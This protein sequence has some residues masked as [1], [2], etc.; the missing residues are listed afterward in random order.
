MV[1]SVS[2]R[3]T[4]MRLKLEFI[5]FAICFVYTL[6]DDYGSNVL[7]YSKASYSKE[8]P[9]RN[10]FVMFFAPWCGHCKRL[11]PTWDELGSKYNIA[12]SR[13]VTI[14]KVDCTV[15]TDLCSEEDVT[16]YPTIKYFP[17]GKESVR[18]KGSR[19]LDSL[20]NFLKQQTG[21][22]DEEVAPLG[23]PEDEDA[24]IVQT[25]SG[26]SPKELTE[27][28]FH[29]HI[30]KGLH[31][32]K[33]YAPWCGH[34]Q[35]LAPVWEQLAQSYGVDSSVQIGKID[36][37]SNRAI[38]TEFEIQ[39]YP[40][41]LWMQDGKVVE[42]YQ[43]PRN[44][45]DLKKYVDTMKAKSEQQTDTLQDMTVP[46][47][48]PAPVVILN[49]D[50]F[51]TTVE[52]GLT[53]VKFFAPWCGHCKR[54]APTWEDLAKKLISQKVFV[55]EVDCS[56]DKCKTLCQDQKVEGYPTLVLYK[57]GPYA[58]GCVDIMTEYSPN[59]C[60]MRLYYPCT[61]EDAMDR[62]MQWPLW[63][64]SKSYARGYGYFLNFWP[65]A[66]QQLYKWLVGDVYIPV[67]WNAPPIRGIKFPI[68]VFSHGLGGCRTTYSTICTE[69]SSNGFF[70]AAI[71]HR[72]RSA[73][74]SYYFRDVNSVP[75]SSEDGAFSSPN[76]SMDDIVPSYVLEPVYYLRVKK[77]LKEFIVRNN[78]VHQ[79]A[80]D[81]MKALDIL[82]RLNRGRF[83]HNVMDVDFSAAPFENTMDVTRV[84]VAGHSFGGATTIITL[85]N[86]K[87]F[88][89]GI[90]LD[91]WMLPVK[92]EAQMFPTIKQPMFFINSEYFQTAKNLQTMRTLESADQ[93]RRMV[94]IRGTSH[95][96]Q[97]DI[98]FLSTSWARKLFRM[99]SPIDRFLAMDI[100]NK[101]ML[102][103]LWHYLDVP[104][105]KEHE[106]FSMEKKVCI[107]GAGPSGLTAIKT[108]LEEKVSPVCYEKTNNFG[109]LW[110]Y[111]DED[112]E[113]I[114]SV[115]KSTII[116]SSKELSAY[117][118]FPPA[119]EL[120]NF[121]HNTS[122]VK[123]LEDYAKAYNLLQYI[124]Y[125]HS[126]LE[127]KYAED[128][129]TTGKWVVKTESQEV[130]EEIFDAVMLCIGHHVYPLSPELPG[131]DE[132]KGNKIHTH[133][134]KVPKGYEDKN[135]VVIG[136][137]NSG[138]DVAVELSRIAKHVYLSTRRGSWVTNRVAAKGYPV[139]VTILSRF[140]D[141]VTKYMPWTLS[142]ASLESMVNY[143]FDHQ[144]YGLRPK[145][146]ILEQHIMINDDMP[147][148]IASG[149]LSI[150]S[151]I[152]HFTENGV[153]FKGENDVEYPIDSVILGTGYQILFPF[154][155]DEVFPPI[156]ENCAMF[157]KNV[158]PPN[159]KHP[160]L[161]VVGLVQPRGSILPISE[162]Q[163]RWAI[164]VFMG[165]C[166]LPGEKAM[167]QDME[168]RK[169]YLEKYF[170][171]SPRHTIQVNFVEYMD[172]IA[173]LIDAKP[174]LA[175][176]FFTDP[177]LFLTMYFGPCYPYQYRMNGPHSWPGA[178]N[179]IL[180]GRKRILAP[181]KS[182]HDLVDVEPPF[183][184]FRFLFAFVFFFQLIMMVLQANILYKEMVLQTNMEKRVCIIGGGPSGLTSIKACIEGGLNPVCYE[185]S[186]N[187][188][189][190][191]R[192]S[193]DRNASS[194]W[195][196]TIINSS[197]ELTA[198]SDFPPPENAPNF[199]HRSKLL[200]YIESYATKFNLESYIKYNH[201][202]IEV[203]FADDYSV[204]GKWI[205]KVQEKSQ[206]VKEEIFDAVL[207]CSGPHVDPYIPSF[208]GLDKFEGKKIHTKSYRIPNEYVDK[209]VLVIGLGNSGGD[210]AV[211]VSR[212]AEIVYLSTRRGSWIVNRVGT[213]GYPLDTILVTRFNNTLKK[214]LPWS[215][216]NTALEVTVNHRFD[217]ADYGIRPKHRI[218]EQHMTVSDDLPNRIASGT[219]EIKND[220][221]HFTKHGVVFKGE[222]HLEYPLDAVII[223]TGYNVSFPFLA[224]KIM[225]LK[226]NKMSLYK[227]GHCKLPNE[228]AM[229]EDIR[230]RNEHLKK[231]F[232]NSQRYSIQV[233][234]IPMI[235]RICVI[236][237]GPSGLTA[238][239][240]CLQEGFIP[241]CYEKTNYIGGLWKY[242]EEE[243]DDDLPS[244]MKSTIINSSKE[245]SCYSDFPP[246]DHYPN[247]M[248]NSRL[249]EYL[250]SYAVRFNLIPYINFNHAVTDITYAD[251]YAST[252][253]WTVSVTYQDTILTDTFDA[254]MVCNGH[255][256][257]PKMPTFPGMDEFK[258]TVAHSHNYKTGKKYED[259]NVVVVGVGNSGGDITV[260][261]SRI[262][263]Q[264]YMSTRRGTWVMSRVE[265]HGRPLDIGLLTRCFTAT[266]LFA[267]K[268]MCTLMENQLNYRFNHAEFG[269]KPKNRLFEQAAMVSDDLPNRI[270]S[271]TVMVKDDIHHFTKNGVV[272]N[273]EENVEYPIDAVVFATGFTIKFPFI[274]EKIISV[275][276]NVVPLF[277]Y[278]FPPHLQHSTL[279]FIGLINPLGSILPMSEMQSRWVL[280]VFQG[281]LKLPSESQMRADIQSKRE[282]ITKKYVA[283]QRHT[284]QVDYI[285]YMDEI[286][287]LIGSTS[288]LNCGTF[289]AKYTLFFL[290]VIV[291]LIGGVLLGFGGWIVLRR[292]FISTFL[293]VVHIHINPAVFSAVLDKGPEAILCAGVM[294]FILGFLG[295]LGTLRESTP[296]LY[297][298]GLSLIVALGIQVAAAAYGVIL[299][300]QQLSNLSEIL[301]RSLENHYTVEDKADTH[302]RNWNEVMISVKAT[303]NRTLTLIYYYR[304]HIFLK[305]NNCCGVHNYTDFEK[306]PKWQKEKISGIVMPSTCCHLE[307]DEES[308][309]QI[310]DKVCPNKPTMANSN[311]LKGCIEILKTY[312]IFP[313]PVAA[314]I[315]IGVGL[316]QV[317]S[318]ILTLCLCCELDAVNID[319]K[320]NSLWN[321]EVFFR[322]KYA[323]E[324]SLY[325]IPYDQRSIIYR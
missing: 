31:F 111:R 87:R 132:F 159:L 307:I 273:S 300:R 48:P 103:F 199:M 310:V 209:R 57:N 290:N 285:P 200:K 164:R 320:N 166:H 98:P 267:P 189:G 178:A 172:S 268:L 134:Y 168:D 281:T 242:R 77:P 184:F 259:M 291:F 70:V 317:F 65:P 19:D 158:F 118:D 269:L 262:A 229:L 182:N 78:Q 4:L 161:C 11:A 258:G 23:L 148:R 180:T 282:R 104:P 305:Q 253:R 71:E 55:A 80:A 113:G 141:H 112:E 286:A 318:I 196:S 173:E 114:P 216:S 91:A 56:K 231:Y 46:D 126:V 181:L 240:T 316:F 142:N 304:N 218:F 162:M 154:V 137:G 86:D 254:V 211:E 35:K 101:L 213:K 279:A 119:K 117:S 22:E 40:T 83:I 42:K 145:H 127:V 9:T 10:T 225:P 58:V 287:E 39:G 295:C 8:V 37:M 177:R 97:S 245:L 303:H 223:A 250:E 24:E 266:R 314:P 313:A 296:I 151:D 174:H 54:L 274:S 129:E 28:T 156:K 203:T 20:V 147:N 312:F 190:L 201:S 260:E 61:H 230:L 263:K 167:M 146:R 96:N 52:S 68:L 252:G 204:T 153:I 60:F 163:S 169:N 292:G 272:F 202:V 15:D 85:A 185:K 76:P 246:P 251:D 206:E 92:A 124:H 179:A 6:A 215:M 130:K 302:T 152:D 248:H 17:V 93:C 271:G 59:G 99:G 324:C 66:F 261:L 102:S 29:K 3:R 1:T 264:V 224:D 226:D 256:I 27:T 309:Y 293:R 220:V 197:K 165:K 265:F 186:D 284:I 191:W 283:S 133:S 106:R 41:L 49:S 89:V 210:I 243:D 125:N 239:K 143:R 175:K 13:L 298:Y 157:Y 234:Y 26:N 82:T 131:L 322:D 62:Q 88:C 136:I 120:A 81:C 176:I 170:V 18:Y 138:G 214:T 34:C 323:R 325:S 311:Y 155:A 25:H 51:K 289:V 14:A 109:G 16:G 38:C 207:V 149:T 275:D 115:M 297:L 50:N 257:N 212:I 44:H 100:N 208:P 171:K 255:H 237:A 107:I 235:K 222:E 108:C 183:I 193:D 32:V 105:N 219:L 270:M 288:L 238:L 140:F 249:L 299:H 315:L 7:K 69:L 110:R 221:H 280:K 75:T 122:V 232:V 84:A 188:G 67:L 94:T 228:Q 74:Y 308:K 123:Y 2:V 53:F 227:L 233:D 217:H 306:A 64:P 194:V 150:K 45:D 236:G 144:L 321:S 73:C 95:Q 276:R 195:K 63:L 116:N 160:T 79:R 30:E 33:F 121:M 198:F 319:N 278:V 43:G 192:Y 36:C 135:V 128:Y 247:F 294:A 47:E 5:L 21:I 277:K 139:D 241:V 301:I 12:K 72:D 205:V 244:V 90:A 187:F